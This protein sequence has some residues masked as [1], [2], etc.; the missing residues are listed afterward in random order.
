LFV[1]GADG[2]AELVNYRVQDHYL[3]VDRLIDRAELRL[4]EK[5]RQKVVRIRRFGG[6]PS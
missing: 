1:V 3:I 4:G 5:G 6:E 2:K